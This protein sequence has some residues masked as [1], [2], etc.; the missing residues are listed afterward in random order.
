MSPMTGGRPAVG[1][2]VSAERKKTFNKKTPKNFLIRNRNVSWGFVGSRSPLRSNGKQ[3]WGAM[4]T[5]I[6]KPLKM[7]N[8]LLMKCDKLIMETK[9]N[10]CTIHSF[11]LS[12]LMTIYFSTKNT[13][14]EV[15]IY[16][17]QYAH[18][19]QERCCNVA[20]CLFM[21]HSHAT[22]Q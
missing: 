13:Y 3:I 16:I 2:S 10:A 19:L 7:W 6:W 1:G 8:L 11:T 4:I 9:K 14:N 21:F 18:F 5:H 12:L 17:S 22:F 15:E 20:R